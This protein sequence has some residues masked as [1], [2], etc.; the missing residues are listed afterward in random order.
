LRLNLDYISQKESFEAASRP[1]TVAPGIDVPSAPN[2]RTN[3][4]QD[5]GWSDTKEQSA[6]LGGE[7]DLTDT[8]TV[9]AHAGGG[10]SDVKRLSDQVPRISTTLAIPAIFRATTSSTLIAQPRTPVSVVCSPPGRSPTRR[11]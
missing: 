8:V 10:K 6:L 2:G 5:W 7:Y 1:F 9:F 4:P 3:L 11:R